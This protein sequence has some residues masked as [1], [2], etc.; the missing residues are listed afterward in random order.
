MGYTGDGAAK[1]QMMSSCQKDVQCQKV[2]HLDYGEGSQKKNFDIMRLTHI[3][4]NFDVTYDSNQ[5][6]LNCA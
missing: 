5:K 2:K 3:D 6:P 1:C 4:V